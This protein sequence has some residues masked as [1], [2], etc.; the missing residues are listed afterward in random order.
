MLSYMRENAGS[1][2]IKVLFTIIVI[3]FVFFY[4]FSALRKPNKDATIAKV[5]N[6]KITMS[7]YQT[8]YKNTIEMYRSLYKNQFNEEMMEKLGLK[9]KVLEDLISREILLQEA[10]RRTIRVTEDEI[11]SAIMS[12]PMFQQDGSFSE[13]MYQRALGYYGITAADFEKDKERELMLKALENIVTR[14]VKVSDQELRD[15]YKMQNE[16]VKIGYLCFEPEKIKDT[17]A[18]PEADIKNY[19]DQH[20][21]EFRQPEKAKVKYITF[22]PAS[23]EKTVEV[24]DR[25][26]VNYYETDSDEFSEPKRVKARHILLKSENKEKDAGVFKKAEEIAAQATKGED[27]EKLA[28]KVSEDKPTAEK[29]GDLGFFKKGDMVKP[30]EEAAFAMKPGEISKPVKSQF[31]WHIIKVEDVKEA[32]IKPLEEVKELIEAELRKEGAQ[33]FVEKEVKR[34]FNRLFKS[35]NLE[36]FAQETGMKVQETDF[37]V[38]GKSPE[39]A[40]GKEIFSKEAFALAKGELSPSFAVGQKYYIIRLED[41][42]ETQIAPMDEEKTVISAEIEKE[43]KLAAAKVNAEKLLMD[44]VQG[45]QTWEG[46]A[47]NAGLEIKNAD[48]LAIGDYIAGIGQS[49]GIREAAFNLDQTKPYGPLPYRAEKGIVIIKFQERSAPADADFA[50]EKD[51]MAQTLLQTKQRELFEQF[52]QGLKAKADTWVD[53]KFSSNL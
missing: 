28:K 36:A 11:K 19:Y 15:M 52:L 30:I 35:K 3:V 8:A 6:S 1:W 49:K 4:G 18:I 27:F 20:K 13:A 2:I 9:Q 22:D 51:R 48:V 24:T 53:K 14:S 50:K 23:F 41:K 16:K 29:G 42:R 40:P 21:E 43:K 46:A 33:K 39:D 26:I 45:R 44:L 10:E 5:G 37:F 31:G 32:R 38:Y 25:E 47:K 34:A 17:F 7:H 12:M